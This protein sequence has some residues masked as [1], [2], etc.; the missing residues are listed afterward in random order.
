ME[1]I[2][3]KF[4]KLQYCIAEH[5][6]ELLLPD[7]IAVNNLLPSFEA[8]VG[9]MPEGTDLMCS[10]S[11]VNREFSP[12]IACKLLV[13]STDVM[14]SRFRLLETE[15]DYSVAL[16]MSDD[17]WNYMICDKEFSTGTV[18]MKEESRYI[19]PV[20]SFFLMMMFGQAAVLRNTILIHASVV[21]K[22]GCGFAFLGKSGTGKSTHS[23]LWLN[24]LMGFSLLN[25]DN[26]AIRVANDGEIWIYGTPWSGKTL[27]YKNE[28][29]SL[30]A[31]VRLEQAL[32]NSFCQKSGISAILTL[33]PGCTSM[34]WNNKLYAV[35]VDTLEIIVCKI[36]V[37]HLKCLPDVEAATLCYEEINKILNKEL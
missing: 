21:E 10:M 33:L 12:D 6:L 16:Q 19:I 4:R 20:L 17:S 28:K 25:D 27:C 31:L 2:D 18:Y 13:D 1:L 15:K 37:G 22:N 29:V 8:F 9:K 11:V 14:G 32:S 34:R 7:T 35:M 26:P 23:R 5:W 36:P 24:S 30:K 3:M